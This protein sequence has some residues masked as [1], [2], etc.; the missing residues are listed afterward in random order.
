MPKITIGGGLRL[1]ESP[2][3]RKLIDFVPNLDLTMNRPV[4]VTNNRENALET[5]FKSK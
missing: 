1:T 3:E 5:L 4:P 2:Q